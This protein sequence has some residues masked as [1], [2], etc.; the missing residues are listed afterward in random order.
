[1][2]R[3][4]PFDSYPQRRTFEPKDQLD[5]IFDTDTGYRAASPRKSPDAIRKFDYVL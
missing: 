1:L 3:H 4:H 2:D 5:K